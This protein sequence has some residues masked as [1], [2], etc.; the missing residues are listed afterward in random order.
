MLLMMIEQGTD[1]LG[2]LRNN[3]IIDD[4]ENYEFVRKF[5]LG[6]ENGEM[7]TSKGYWNKEDAI[8][9]Y[10]GNRLGT[11]IFDYGIENDYTPELEE[12]DEDEE[13]EDD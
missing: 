13:W 11:I 5:N 12:F 3:V 9:Y 10:T 1:R 4:T 6:I 7:R 2:R 8:T